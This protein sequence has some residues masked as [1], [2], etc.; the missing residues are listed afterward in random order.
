MKTDQ[1]KTS[2]KIDQKFLYKTKITLLPKK[3]DLAQLRNWRPHVSFMA[4]LQNT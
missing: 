4:G 2:D 1:E 3:D